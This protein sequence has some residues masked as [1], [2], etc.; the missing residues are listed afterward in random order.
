MRPDDPFFAAGPQPLHEAIKMKHEVDPSVDAQL[1]EQFF[2]SEEYIN[3]V[4]GTKPWQLHCFGPPGCG[5]V[6]ESIHNVLQ[7]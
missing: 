6:S 1:F 7:D 5:K 4:E 2:R 3:W